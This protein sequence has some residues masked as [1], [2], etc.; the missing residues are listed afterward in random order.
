M[1]LAQR[2]AKIQV[3]AK[4]ELPNIDHYTLE[5]L[6]VMKIDFGKAHLGRSYQH[7]WEV[8]QEWILWFIQHYPAPTK[9]SHRLVHKFVEKQIEL[10]ENWNHRVPVFPT[11]KDMQSANV[12]EEQPTPKNLAKAKGM[13]SRV[14]MNSPGSSVPPID[15]EED[16]FDMLQE[17]QLQQHLDGQ[18]VTTLQADVMSLQDRMGNLESLL[19]QV[20]GHL[21]PKAAETPSGK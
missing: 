5:E 2:L 10:A 1:T 21:Q 4:P 18:T 13:P 20:L 8:E 15:M 17:W 14:K 19:Q 16:E 3:Q 7:M 9:L 12:T 6:K 11:T